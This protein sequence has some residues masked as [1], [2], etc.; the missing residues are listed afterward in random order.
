MG[1]WRSVLFK[2]APEIGGI[3]MIGKDGGNVKPPVARF[4]LPGYFACK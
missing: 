4:V 3:F 1:D 2:L